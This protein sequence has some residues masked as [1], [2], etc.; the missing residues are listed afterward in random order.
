MKFNADIY[1]QHR[2]IPADVGD[3]LSFHLV[4]TAGQDFHV[5]NKISLNMQHGLAETFA[6]MLMVSCAAS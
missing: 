3:P 6:Q 2:M 4:S 1:W 5:G